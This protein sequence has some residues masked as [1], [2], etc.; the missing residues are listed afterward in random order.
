MTA[1]GI[2]LPGLGRNKKALVAFD[3]AVSLNLITLFVW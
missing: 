2:A 1:K 3:L